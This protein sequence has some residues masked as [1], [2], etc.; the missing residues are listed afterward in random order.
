MQINGSLMSKDIEL[1]RIQNGRVQPIKKELLP[2]YLQRQDNFTGWL[3]ERAIDSH[4]TNSRLL[5]KALRLTTSTDLEVVLLVNASTITDTYWFRAQGSPLTYN[6]V[7]FKQNLYDKMAL[8][9]DFEAFGHDPEPTPELTNIGSFE[10]AWRLIDGRWWI[11]KQGKPEELF[12]ELFIYHL[13][14][15]LGYPMAEYEL[16]GGYIRSPDF[17][18]SAGVNFESM[19]G[20]VR[21]SEDYSESYT[22]LSVLSLEAADNFIPMIALDTICF[23]A[24][25]HTRNYGVLR[26]VDT[27]AVLDLAPNFDNNIALISTGYGKTEVS[28]KDLLTR[29]FVDFLKDTPMALRAYNEKWRRE[30]TREMVWECIRQVPIEVNGEYV[31]DFVLN[32]AD[33]LHRQLDADI[34]QGPQMT[35]L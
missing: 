28:E 10:K 22:N 15:M 1:A 2:L 26:D 6:D 7:R 23:N 32:R 5:K 31:A 11:Y 21:D 33:F 19:W 29:L 13:G 8:S 4:R 12:S 20:L 14:K 24:D 3:E 34:R 35:T 16:D 25:R 27:G 17:T 9:G 30:I 18:N